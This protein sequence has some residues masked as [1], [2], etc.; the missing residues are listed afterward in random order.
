MLPAIEIETGELP[1]YVIIWLHGLG[2]DGNDFLPIVD[3]LNLP[4]NKSIRFVFPHAPE[5]PIT[6]NNGYVM[7]AWYDIKGSNFNA[8]EDE[9]GIRRSQRAIEALIE[10]EIENG[11][12][13]ERIVVAGFSQGGVMA[14]QVGLRYTK[15]LA[16]IL[17][18]S[19]YLSLSESLVAEINRK[20]LT[21]PIFM[22]HGIDDNVIPLSY[23]IRSKEMIRAVGYTP[24]WHDYS[25]MH[26]VCNQ[27]LHDISQWIQKV[28]S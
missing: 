22:A 11:I 16:G 4:L 26:S 20:N 24:E 6:I 1:E 9:L 13:T 7:R 2:A 23:A 21:I 8:S 14:L 12:A 15:P 27:E 19:C 17:A 25:M 18:L 3:Q 28:F 5:R 10:R